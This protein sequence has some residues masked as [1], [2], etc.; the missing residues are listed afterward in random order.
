MLPKPDLF[1]SMYEMAY[2]LCHFAFFGSY[3]NDVLVITYIRSEKIIRFGSVPNRLDN[4]V[5]VTKSFILIN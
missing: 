2:I 4:I 3:R 1:V 5:R